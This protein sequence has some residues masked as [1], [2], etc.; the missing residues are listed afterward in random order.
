MVETENDSNHVKLIRRKLNS[1]QFPPQSF[2]IDVCFAAQCEFVLKYHTGISTICNLVN[3]RNE[4]L[5]KLGVFP[6]DL[7]VC[8][9]F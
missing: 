4:M 5:T 9:T 2:Q 6:P 1:K 3:E 7:D 8:C